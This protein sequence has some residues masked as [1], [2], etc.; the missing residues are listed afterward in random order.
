MSPSIYIS[1]AR[2]RYGLY[3]IVKGTMIVSNLLAHLA[4]YSRLQ[5][6]CHPIM[7]IVLLVVGL[8]TGRMAHAN[9]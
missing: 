3:C 9:A 5:R 6:N 7:M 4:D 1:S 8:S 2:L